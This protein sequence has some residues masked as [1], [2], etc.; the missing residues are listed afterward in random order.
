[1]PLLVTAAIIEHEGRIL[2]TRRRPDAPYPLWWEFPGG[3]VER[4]EDPRDCIVRE[5][6]EELAISVSVRGIYDVVFYRYPQRA[7]VVLAYRCDWVGGEIQ[8]LEVAEHRW[9][10]PGELAG[11]QLLPA[12][13]PLVERLCREAA[14]A[15]PAQL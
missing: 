1:M 4:E 6:R 15:D 7:V 11:F 10:T 12:D 13:G 8:N 9:V 14:G 3:K 5:L 2:L